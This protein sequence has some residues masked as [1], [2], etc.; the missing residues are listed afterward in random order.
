MRTSIVKNP[1][2]FARKLCRT[3]FGR[4]DSSRT[5][6]QFLIEPI[7]N[8]MLLSVDLIGIPDWVEQGPAPT[9]GGQVVL[10]GGDEVSGAIEAVAVHPTDPNTIYVGAINGGVWKTT[11]GGS[12]WTPLTDQLQSLSVG[13]VAFSPLDAT[14]QTLFFGVGNFSAGGS[15]GGALTGLFRTT[16]G[17]TTW[18]SLGLAGERIREVIPTAIGT[19]LADQVVLVASRTNG[20]FR[21]TNGGATFTPISGTN[22]LPAGDVSHIT[23]NPGNPNQFYAGL[24]GSGVY[25][26][27]NGGL[28]WTPVNNDGVG[29]AQRI[30]LSVSPAAG[31]PVYAA[32]INGGVLSNVFR[33]TDQGANWDPIGAAPPP[34]NPGSQANTHFGILAHNTNANLVWVGGDRAPA[35]PFVANMYLGDA[36]ADTW[37]NIIPSGILGTAPHADTRDLVYNSLGQI[38]SGNDGGITVMVNPDNVATRTWLSINGDISPTEFYSVALDT[39][40]TTIFGGTQDTGSTEQSAAGSLTW[41]EIGSQAGDGGTADAVNAGAITQHFTMGNNVNNFRRRTF[42]NGVLFSEDVMDLTGLVGGDTSTT[43]FVISQYVINTVDLARLAFGRGRLYESSDQGEN[44]TPL[45]TGTDTGVS[46]IAYGGRL[47]GAGNAEILYAGVGGNLYLR[48]AAGPNLTRLTNYTGGAP[49][50]I[51]LHPEDWRRAYVTDGTAVWMTTDAGQTWTN[52]TGNMSPLNGRLQTVAVFSPTG[53]AGDEVILAGG[54]AGVYR[55]R[56]PEAGPNAVWTEYG[57]GLPNAV[58]NDT[59]YYGGA[60]DILLTGTF[61][62][63]AWTVAD[64]SE[65]L[66][67]PGVLVI[68]G[69]ENG[70]AEDDIIRLIRQAANPS[71]LE[72]YINSA[73]P[74]AVVQM[75]VLEQINVNSLGGN[76]TLIIDSTNGLINVV[77]GIRYDG[78]SGNG[79]Q[80]QLLQTGGTIHVSDTYTV[81]PAIGAGTSVIVGAPADGTQRVF[82][83]NLSPVL[84]VVPVLTLTVNATP[85]NNAISYTSGFVAP[86]RVAIDSHEPIEFNN[87]GSL[88]INAL[89]GTDT[90]SI[91]NPLTPAAL[92]GI[93]VNGGDPGTGDALVIIGVGAAASVNTGTGVITGTTGV[94]GVVPITYTTIETL[95]LSAVGSLLITT[96][97]ADDSVVVTP[98]LATGTN[99]GSVES[100]GAVPQITFSNSG[101]F[102]AT[103]GTGADSLTVIGSSGTDIAAVSA[104]A[105]NITGRRAVNVTGAESIRVDG[106]NGADTFN[107]TP[108]ELTS[109]FIDGGA[110]VG[111]APGDVLNIAAGGSSVTYN[112]GAETDEGSFVVGTNQAVSFDHIESIGISGTAS[113]VING[114]NGPD[115]ITVIARDASTHAGTDGAQ[116]FTVSLNG[117]P[118]LLFTNVL[119]LAVNA[120]S[121]SDQVTLQTPAP[122]NAIWN[123]DVTVNGGAPASDTDRLIVQTPSAAAEIATFTPTASD[124]GTLSL[125]ALSSVVTIVSTEALTWDGQGDND[126]ITVVGTGNNDVIT[127][128]PGATDQAGTI[129]VNGLLALVYQNLGSTGSITADGG[130]GTDTLVVH[131]TSAND[132]F[133]VGAAGQVNL[134]ARVILNSQNLETLTL[135]GNAGNDTFTLV[136]A[137]SASVYTTMNFN[138]GTQ[139]SAT[140]DRVNLIATG[141]DDNIVVS[142]QSVTLGTKTVQSTGVED[143]RLD[144]QGGND[145]LTYNGVEG[146]TENINVISSGIAGG[147][148]VSVPT[149]ALV[150]FSGVE[151]IDVNGNT[152]TPTETDTLTFSGTNAKDVFEIHLAADGTDL[153]PILV[154]NTAAA[155][156]LLTLRNYTNFETLNVLGRDGEDTFNVYVDETGPSRNLFINGELPAG[157]KKQTDNLNI[158]YTPPRP[159]IIHSAATQDPDAGLVDLDYENGVAHFLVQYDGIEQ[160]VIRRA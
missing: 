95:N 41:N 77:N 96:T 99:S 36:S 31:N 12:D 9:T 133:T 74:V 120:L 103:L 82:F 80:L 151:R 26:S 29:A 46:A 83:E 124:A 73:T 138:G 70:F 145:L 149:V 53:T 128:N 55:T 140:G 1:I 111:G 3:A 108:S 81:G 66:D 14:S 5:R 116:D 153:D 78:G 106:Q 69:D 144:A 15:L 37:T 10:P 72:V 109:F 49:T 63:G 60:T 30:E 100:S 154:L 32:L 94:A 142:G 57:A 110:P 114:T 122:N 157:K 52:I 61:G 148:Q 13:D 113:A 147:G 130:A 129:Q 97:G 158:I 33:S 101:S 93:T 136:P 22:G 118:E 115:T 159:D 21:S 28:N 4:S 38:L 48:T 67:V 76:D 44:V 58:V 137:I 92:T 146:I 89:G 7:E 39:F 125:I 11:N 123:V 126:N 54:L 143:I 156:T 34:I 17:G 56:N 79:D 135:E 40:S 6:S 62:R 16:D 87:K 105:V 45:G 134:N 64:A 8:R 47:N 150:N 107:V 121:G 86:G 27:D 91:N 131:G 71:L 90:V 141:G 19:G 18:Q 25:R 84:D 85:A 88:V 104:T 50:D 119:N 59:R 23:A 132:T 112:P 102:T 65:T 20:L 42:V 155:A 35:S 68:E 160:V 139:S 117:G 75:S 51:A 127:H 24:P 152:P 43:G 98:G 2:A